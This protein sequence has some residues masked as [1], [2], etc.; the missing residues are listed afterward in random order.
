MT[1][2]L[3]LRKN[4]SSAFFALSD[5]SLKVLSQLNFLVLQILHL[6]YHGLAPLMSFCLNLLDIVLSSTFFRLN[7]P[8]K[9]LNFI[10]LLTL[11]HLELA[12]LGPVL[13][14][15]SLGLLLLLIVVL[16][17][18]IHVLDKL[19]LVHLRLLVPMISIIHGALRLHLD[20]VLHGMV[21]R[22]H[23]ILSLVHLLMLELLVHLAE[24]LS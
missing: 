17:V 21:V 8:L 3:L 7:L 24:V 13:L 11:P 19:S 18:L 12:L 15:L 14:L 9:L 1:H 16:L 10:L 22:K 2:L 5:V 6:W 23:L 4:H 20:L